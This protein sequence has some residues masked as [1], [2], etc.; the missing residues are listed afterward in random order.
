M[1]GNALATTGIAQF[2]GRGGLDGHLS[3]FTVHARSQ[4]A[5][6]G[7]NVRIEFR[8]LGTNGDIAVAQA[9]AVFIKQV[10][11]MPQQQTA[12][13]ALVLRIR[14]R[15]MVTDVAQ[16]GGTQQGVAQGM[17]GHVGIAVSQ[18]AAFPRNVHAAQPQ[19]SALD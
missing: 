9:V 12:V 14:I 16:G 6:H 19:G 15:E 3:G 5:L 13:D 2:L 11:H 18:Q 4:F 17:D 1:G 8:L 7:G 10:H